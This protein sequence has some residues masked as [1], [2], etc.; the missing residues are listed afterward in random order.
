MG[1]CKAGGIERFLKVQTSLY[2]IIDSTIDVSLNLPNR[3]HGIFVADIA[4]CY[5]TIPAAGEDSLAT[6]I[7]ACIKIAYK[8]ANEGTRYNDHF[9]SSTIF[10]VPLLQMH[11]GPQQFQ[12]EHKAFTWSLHRQD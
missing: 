2:W 1:S 9:L 7:A 5:E 6:A 10:T 12:K 3:L 4:Q 8:Q 11:V